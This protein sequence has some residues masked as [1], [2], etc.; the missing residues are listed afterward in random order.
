MRAILLMV[1]AGLCSIPARADDLSRRVGVGFDGGSDVLLKSKYSSLQKAD[2][3]KV[4]GFWART[5]VSK[6]WGMGFSYD[7]LS[8]NGSKVSLQPELVSAFYQVLPGS[9]WNPNI[10]AGIGMTTVDQVD[11]P[12]RAGLSASGGLGFDFFV[13]HHFS[14]GS[15]V[16]YLDIDS[17]RDIHVFTASLKL[18][19]W[20]GG[21]RLP[22]QSAAVAPAPE[23]PKSVVTVP[24]AQ[25][26]QQAMPT[27]P[28]QAK[29]VENAKAAPPPQ[30][31]LT[32]TVPVQAKPV[33]NIKAAP[34]PA[35]Q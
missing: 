22:L 9:R 17:N 34:S 25:Q 8:F 18:G 35:A 33:E 1:L 12:H 24:A 26:Q 31:Q 21:H 27:A 32:P 11:S 29:P 7:Y 5:G 10:H 16:D 23:M 13:N 3:E 6:H 30:Q 4:L 28:V 2:P 15:S 14:L 20:A 19:F